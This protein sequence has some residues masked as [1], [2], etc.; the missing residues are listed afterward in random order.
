MRN[1]AKAENIK[2]INEKKMER[3]HKRKQ[4]MSAEKERKRHELLKREIEQMSPIRNK[5]NMTHGNFNRK[6]MPNYKFTAANSA[7]FKPNFPD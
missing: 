5:L 6:S 2:T 7:L 4:L 1:L 3:A